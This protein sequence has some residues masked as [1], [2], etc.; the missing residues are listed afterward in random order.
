MTDLSLK[1][2]AVCDGSTPPLSKEEID[3][4]KV[5][6]DSNW[7][8]DEQAKTLMRKF[9][10]KGFAKATYMANLAAFI[11]D[12]EGHHADIAF[13]WGYCQVTFTSHEAGGL[14]GNDFICAAKL[15]AA[16]AV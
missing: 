4:L 15:D 2:C 8:I 10:F 6:L 3:K 1:K 5:E 9:T 7:V 12:K 16:I 13:G 11:S 14:T